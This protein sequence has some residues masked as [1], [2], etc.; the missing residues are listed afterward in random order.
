MIILGLVTGLNFSVMAF[1]TPSLNFGF[2]VALAVLLAFIETP[3][4]ILTGYYIGIQMALRDNFH[5]DEITTFKVRRFPYVSNVRNVY[6]RL[7][8]FFSETERA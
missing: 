4:Q 8:N 1:E 2:V 7:E 6:S 3:V 5:H